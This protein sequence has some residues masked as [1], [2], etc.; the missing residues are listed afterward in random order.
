MNTFPYVIRVVSEITESTGQVHGWHMRYRM[1]LMNAGVP[2][3]APVAGIA[4]GLCMKA[5]IM[6]CFPI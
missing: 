3:A 5:M 1:S 6:W 2:V 4:M